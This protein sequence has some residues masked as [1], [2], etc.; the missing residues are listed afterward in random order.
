MS[1]PGYRPYS[2]R[3]AALEQVSPS[4]TRVRFTS[5]DLADVTRHGPDQRVKVV[6]PLPGTGLSSFPAGDDWYARWR[7]QG[8]RERNPIRTYT[9]RHC[10]PAARELV[11]DFVA[12]G[13][14]GPAT[15]W[16]SRAAVGD[17]VLV[18]APD[19]TS[20]DAAGG[21][22]W[23][24]GRAST[25]LVAGDETAVPAI[26]SILESLP[27]DASGVAFLEVPSTL[28]V[29]PVV[30][31]AGVA[32][33]WLP[34]EGEETASHGVALDREVRRW[35]ARHLGCSRVAVGAAAGSDADPEVLWEVPDAEVRD[36][37]YAWIAGEAGAV[38]GLRRHLVRDL[39]VEASRVAFMGYWK[40]GRAEN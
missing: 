8:D 27:D 38:T 17:E 34:R 13:D 4:F 30:A 24:P 31:P 21:Y 19:A 20:T 16:V 15:R 5:D 23:Q 36:G 40:A 14:T 9:L 6:L 3:V 10:D 29:Q 1:K 18:L 35:A 28:D 37:L 7:R 32:V 2:V 26:V 39:G 12:H 25:L 11:V 22:A 33:R